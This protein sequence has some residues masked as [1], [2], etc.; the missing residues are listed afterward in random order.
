VACVHGCLGFLTLPVGFRF[1]RV[2]VACRMRC[3]NVAV[4]RFIPSIA[5]SK[6]E[7]F[8]SN[9]SRCWSAFRKQLIQVFF[10]RTRLFF[11]IGQ[12]LVNFKKLLRH[13]Y[14]LSSRTRSLVILIGPL[15]ISQK[16]PIEFKQT[17][18]I[19]FRQNGLPMRP[20]LAPRGALMAI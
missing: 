17:I 5:R 13:Q 9:T 12:Y 19:G 3:S 8:R 10:R 18:D 15:H 16:L 4:T 2:P 6:A 20:S 14:S 11:K 7:I 1:F